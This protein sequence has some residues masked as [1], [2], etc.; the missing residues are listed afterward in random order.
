MNEP[1][2]DLQFAKALGDA[3]RLK[4]LRA[5]GEHACT[6]SELAELAAVRQPTATHHLQ[7]L[8]EAGLLHRHPEGKQVFFSVNEAFFA[9]CCGNLILRLAPT[10]EASAAIQRCGCCRC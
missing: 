2:P 6:V 9:R 3:T 8:V 5:C 10:T 4:M 7:V 1:D